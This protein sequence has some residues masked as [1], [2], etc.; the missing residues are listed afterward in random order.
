M[1]AQPEIRLQL[2]ALRALIAQ[3]IDDGDYLETFSIC[4]EAQRAYDAYHEGPK[5]A[6]GSVQ[7]NMIEQ[8][9]IDIM[10]E[11]AEAMNR[12]V[13]A[14][15]SIS[16]SGCAGPRLLTREIGADD[17]TLALSLAH[18][19]L[20][21]SGITDVQRFFGHYRRAMAYS[22]MGDYISELETIV[23]ESEHA[24][25]LADTVPEW[26]D[27]LRCYENAAQ[28]AF[29]A[30]H[31]TVHIPGAYGPD[32]LPEGLIDAIH[33]LHAHMCTKIEEDEEWHFIQMWRAGLARLQL[34]VLGIWEGDPTLSE[35]WGPHLMTLMAVFRHRDDSDG[36]SSADLEEE[37]AH[38]GIRWTHDQSGQMLL[39]D[40]PE[41]RMRPTWVVP[42]DTRDGLQAAGLFGSEFPRA[43]R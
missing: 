20:A 7:S 9:F 40:T 39:V 12:R 29:Y 6:Q 18:K 28:D 22:N 1:D 5:P 42:D 38:H 36:L 43:W 15:R 3:S 34:P 24:A 17:F 25:M 41:D 13:S 16:I 30:V 21:Y 2:S 23:P 32:V 19:S 10:S 27:A 33:A 8:T 31:A 4:S 35:Y 26:S 14:R 11:T 37:F